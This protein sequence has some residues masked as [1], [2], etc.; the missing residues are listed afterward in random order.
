MTKINTENIC[1]IQITGI[2]DEVQVIDYIS[3]IQK[4]KNVL[5]PTGITGERNLFM[6]ILQCFAKW[7][8]TA[9]INREKKTTTQSINQPFVPLYKN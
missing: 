3:K 8:D 9:S 6:A 1:K 5:N 7:D 4:H 2:F